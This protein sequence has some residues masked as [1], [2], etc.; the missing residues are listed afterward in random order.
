MRRFTQATASADDMIAYL[1]SPKLMEKIA[2]SRIMPVDFRAP[3][4]LTLERL[5]VE[6]EV[7][8]PEPPDAAVTRLLKCGCLEKRSE[9][10]VTLVS[11]VLKTILQHWWVRPPPDAGASVQA[12]LE[13]FFAFLCRTIRCLDPQRLS[14]SLSK[15]SYTAK[16]TNNEEIDTLLES[17]LQLEWYR[18][19]CR[20]LPHGYSLSSDVG[21]VFDSAGRID[22]YVNTTLCWGIEIAREGIRLGAHLARFRPGGIYHGMVTNGALKHWIVVNFCTTLP[23]TIE[24]DVLYVNYDKTYT[25]F[26]LHHHTRTFDP[27][28]PVTE[29]VWKPGLTNPPPPSPCKP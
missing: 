8:V 27:I 2:A 23:N 11:P 18:A 1:L 29:A 6:N 21:R 22:F 16:T 12:G 3:D 7:E 20:V 25:S 4:C 28:M 24:P 14:T 26:K 13:G 19:S 17:A 5:L 15:S 9:R 10:H